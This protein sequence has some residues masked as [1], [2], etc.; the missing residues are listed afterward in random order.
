MGPITS[1][2]ARYQEILSV[3]QSSRW[4]TCRGTFLRLSLLSAPLSRINDRRVHQFVVVLARQR[5]LQSFLAF[6]IPPERFSVICVLTWIQVVEGQFGWPS[7]TCFLIVPRH[8]F[9]YSEFFSE[10]IQCTLQEIFFVHSTIN[11]QGLRS[12]AQNAFN[13]VK[14]ALFSRCFAFFLIA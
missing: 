10:A 8:F 6:D 5:L 12:T 2:Q 4:C 9:R 7:G 13:L 14:C 1:T 11:T 3:P